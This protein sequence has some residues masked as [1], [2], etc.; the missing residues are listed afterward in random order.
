M[1]DGTRRLDRGAIIDS[2]VDPVRPT[3]AYG[4]LC[5]ASPG[6]SE[7]RRV[8]GSTTGRS[9]TAR[10]RPV[11]PAATRA[12]TRRRPATQP[13]SRQS[14][15]QQR[16]NAQAFRKRAV[17]AAPAPHLHGGPVVA[18][19]VA[20]FVIAAVLF[21]AVLARV[22]LLQT[23]QADALRGCGQG[24]ANDGAGAQGPPRHDL[25]PRRGDLALSV[26]ARTV[27]A[28]PKLVARSGRHRADA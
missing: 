5:V 8:D 22:T 4:R 1:R 13:P 17:V 3:R 19:L 24:A 28:N 18:P 26:P 6:C 9:R 2:D 16:R 12:S 21:L 7:R 14:C 10:R 15:R 11:H 27:I 23:V 20:V 25:R